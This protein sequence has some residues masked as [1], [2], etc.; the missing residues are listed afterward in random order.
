MI[1]SGQSTFAQG[2]AGL[3]R[4]TVH[5]PTNSKVLYGHRLRLNASS[6]DKAH[7]HPGH[8]SLSDPE[9]TYKRWGALNLQSCELFFLLIL[10]HMV[11]LRVLIS[12]I[13]LSAVNPVAH[14]PS[15][16]SLQIWPKLWQT[17]PP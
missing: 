16:L 6:E 4:L 11:Y 10:G 15:H 7:Q 13:K 3:N 8:E 12:Q 17:I 1:S 5:I 2:H 9:A 14:P